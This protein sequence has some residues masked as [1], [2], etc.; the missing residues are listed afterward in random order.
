MLVVDQL[1]KGDRSLRTLAWAVLA[2]IF[3]LLGGLWRVQ[4][5]S[6]DRYRAQQTT[7]SFRTVRIPAMR[8]KILDRNGGVMAGN[9][10]RYRVNLYL[11]ELRPQF[12]A[13]YRRERAR[14]LAAK[15]AND[16]P[17]GFN[18]FR[19]I[20]ERFHKPKSTGRLAAAEV[21][22]LSRFSRYS[23]VSNTAAAVAAR[24]GVAIP[25]DEARLQD[26]YLNR[27]ALPFALVPNCTPRQVAAITEQ[28]WNLPGVALEMTPVRFYAHG[29]LAAHLIGHLGRDDSYDEDE[30]HFSYRL[31]DYRGVMGLEGSFDR[32]LRGIAGARSILVNS[33][34][35][36]QAGGGEVIAEPQP[37]LNI[38]T[39]IDIDVQKAAEQALA[40]V[41]GEERGAVVVMNPLNGDV[42]AM[43][44]APSFDPAEFIDGV[45]T[46][47]YRDFYLKEPERR[48]FNRAVY[49]EYSPGSTFKILHA[50]A[51]LENG[52]DPAETFI[53]EP[54]PTKPGKGAFYLGRRKIE[55]TAPPGTYDFRRAFIRSS[56]SYFIHH[57]LRL[58]WEKLLGIG[59]R[60]GL[61]EPTNI[62]LGMEGLGY[63]PTPELARERGMNLG[64]LANVSIG[65]EITVTPLQ[66]AVAVSAVANGGRVY[67]PRVIDRFEPQDAASAEP[68]QTIKAGQVRSEIG[69]PRRC[70]DL[71][72][73]AMRDDVADD[74]GTGK[75]SRIHG[76]AVC[77]KTG[78][79][80]I[81]GNGRKDKVTWF[82]SFAPYEAPRYT[83]IVMVESGASGGGTCAPV[84]REIYTRLRDIEQTPR[85]GLS[86]L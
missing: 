19:W 6:H 63:C 30:G 3:L 41:R 22:Y 46:Q 33:A 85:R 70:F 47:R 75:A 27:R 29:T 14:Y 48:E 64:N 2:G 66:L 78:T 68:V 74:E 20:A 8:G 53:V 13:A 86:S 15:H 76:F 36:R 10:P 43:A 4:V 1:N 34:G 42:L 59:R 12:E 7:Q 28:G 58:G 49:G 79:A 51:L 50:V 32:E 80:E 54:N 35:Y 81:K 37:G 40:A 72:R 71:V 26:H 56:N 21:E 73:A 61:G 16:A 5:M 52:L 65:Q 60:F 38:V 9:A 39:T 44:S 17:D 25:V 11:E 67:Y 18:L 55:D 82:A 31:P 62:H 57:G 23:V 83:I 84:A 24:L 69:A 45:P 77:G